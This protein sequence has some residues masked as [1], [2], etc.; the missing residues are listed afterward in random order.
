[1][2]MLAKMECQNI[3]EFRAVTK[4]GANAK[5]INWRMADVYGESSTKYSK[6]EI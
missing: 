4:E 5:E 6:V 1:M 2:P 3:I